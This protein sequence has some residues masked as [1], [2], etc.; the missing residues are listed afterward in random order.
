[1][2]CFSVDVF[3]NRSAFHWVI[4]IPKDVA[5]QQLYLW[6]DSSGYSPFCGCVIMPVLFRFDMGQFSSSHNDK[7]YETLV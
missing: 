3:Y 1:M 4:F 6:I 2:L 5:S 7:G